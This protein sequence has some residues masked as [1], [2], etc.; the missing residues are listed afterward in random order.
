[1]ENN[2]DQYPDCAEFLLTSSGP[3]KQLTALITQVQRC[4]KA[5]K[6]Q[7]NNTFNAAVVYSSEVPYAI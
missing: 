1:M 3:N 4:Y 2:A 5:G 6:Q 7:E